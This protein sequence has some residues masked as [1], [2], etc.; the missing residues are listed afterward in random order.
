MWEGYEQTHRGCYG[1]LE[2]HSERD[3]L[4][5]LDVAEI[6]LVTER[7]L[8]HPLTR[9]HANMPAPNVVVKTHL[10]NSQ[11]YSQL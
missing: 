1:C 7:L 2:I 3:L 11:A 6:A 9:D 4:I 8:T 5:L 10:K